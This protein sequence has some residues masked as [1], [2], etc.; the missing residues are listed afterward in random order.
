MKKLL[1]SILVCLGMALASPKA[2]ACQCIYTAHNILESVTLSI[3]H[4]TAPDDIYVLKAKITDTFVSNFNGFSQLGY[5]LQ[6]LHQYMGLILLSDTVVLSDTIGSYCYGGF[7]SQP[8]SIGDTLILDCTAFSTDSISNSVC[9]YYVV[10]HNDTICNYYA[11]PAIPFM[12]CYPAPA[13]PIAL[14]S[15]CKH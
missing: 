12:S 15:F 11:P 3:Q 2:N 6:V 5:R 13:L 10:I 14:I 7:Y 1:F 4:G 8:A 9:N